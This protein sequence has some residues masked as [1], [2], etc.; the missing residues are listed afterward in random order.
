MACHAVQHTVAIG[1]DGCEVFKPRFC[2]LAQL[3]QRNTVMCFCKFYA[4]LAVK[5]VEAKPAHLAL[6]VVMYLALGRQQAAALALQMRSY[7]LSV[8]KPW[9]NLTLLIFGGGSWQRPGYILKEC[10][11]AGA[12]VRTHLFRGLSRLIIDSVKRYAS[13]VFLQKRH[14]ELR[15]PQAICENC[16]Y[17]V[18]KVLRSDYASGPQLSRDTL[19]Y[20]G[21]LLPRL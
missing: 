19:G 15:A 1:T 9:I 21:Y 12:E 18:R 11:G 7:Q 17:V 3:A 14:V 5:F 10:H 2:R 16:I 4:E 8:F 13:A 6:V 20:K